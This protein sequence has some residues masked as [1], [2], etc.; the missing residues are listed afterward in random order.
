MS[1]GFAVVPTD[2]TAAASQVKTLGSNAD[3]SRPVSTVGQQAASANSGYMT[4]IA[5]KN[6]TDCFEEVGAALEKR[7]TN[8]AEA[9]D[10]CAESYD[11]TD[12]E[13]ANPFNSYLSDLR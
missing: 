2:I 9:L 5:I 6:F 12:S 11:A 3:A 8:H 13:V 10:E 7:L 1:N 4:S